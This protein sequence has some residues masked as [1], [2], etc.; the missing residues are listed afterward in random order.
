MRINRKGLKMGPLSKRAHHAA[1]SIGLIT[2]R[3]SAN[4]GVKS[5]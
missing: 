5:S 4:S 1:H 2:Y 3:D